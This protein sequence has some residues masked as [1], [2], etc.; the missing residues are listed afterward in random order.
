MMELGIIQQG[1]QFLCAFFMGSLWGLCYDVLWG[2]RHTVPAITWLADGFVGL[3]ILVGNWILFFYV[4][5]GQYR[6]FFFASSVLGF[7]LWR[8]TLSNLFRR[9]SCEFWRILFYPVRV[10]SRILK[11]I[12]EKLKKFFKTPFSNRKKSVK[13][14][15]QQ[16]INGGENS[17]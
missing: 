7:F 13:I 1:R 17:A 15:G 3:Y 10:I 12:I 14:K 2:L 8:K 4:G 11:K 16:S 6:I 5:E 9:G